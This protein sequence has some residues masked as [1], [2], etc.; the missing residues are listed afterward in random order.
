M[1][2][3]SYS[4]LVGVCLFCLP[5]VLSGQVSQNGN[6][7]QAA[8]EQAL[9]QI[10]AFNNDSA[11]VILSRLAAELSRTGDLSSPF[12]AKVRMRRAEALEK[13]DQD[14]QAIRELLQ[15][16]E[17]SKQA[18]YWKEYANAQLSLARLYEKRGMRRRCRLRLAQA[19]AAVESNALDSLYPRLYIRLSSY[20]RIFARRDSALVYARQVVRK[21]PALG[22]EEHAATG[23]MLLGMLL[24]DHSH[25]RAI[26]HFQQAAQTY[27][28]KGN[29]SGYSYMMGNISKLYLK[30]GYPYRALEY[31]D[32]FLLAARHAEGLGQHNASFLSYYYEGRGNIFEALGE[33]DSAL[34]YTR[35]EHALRSRELVE[36]N[37][38][39]IIEI[40]AQFKDEQKAR[41]I[42]EQEQLLAFEQSRRNGLVGLSLI[43]LFFMGVFF[44]LYTALRA[45]N[46]KTI[47][48]SNT[49][50]QTNE[51]LTYSLERQMALQAEIHH[52]VK[53]NLQVIISLLDAQR[54]GIEDAEALESLDA[55]SSRIYSMAAVHQI[56][57]QR[58]GEGSISLQDYALTLCQHLRHFSAEG[59]QAQFQLELK[60]HRFNLETLMPIGILLNEM[61]TNSLKYAVIPGRQLMIRMR[62]QVCGDGFCLNYQDNGP[63]F[64]EGELVEREGGL[65][66]YL[67]KSMVR[68]LD[69]RL[70]SHNENGAVY[71]VFFKE[72]HKPS[73]HEALSYNDR[74]G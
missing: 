67:L 21:A 13:A 1:N 19:T 61:V 36:S 30:H 74:R 29:Y 73:G 45:A 70:Q 66:T 56:L 51:E 58:K 68:Q 11:I 8:F 17:A 41:K 62:L 39:K 22:Q 32:S 63:G 25:K 5:S 9:A 6:N 18:G 46:R 27:R 52:R 43:L 38:E 72:K 14:E 60:S 54:E 33:L 44:Y 3:N 47:Q 59:E 50:R 2:N 69:G 7:Q 53:N 12:G 34:F 23:H 48:Q 65:G 20:H 28:R 31:S 26:E 10:E 49:I 42:E 24:R 16:S 64:P 57:C 71:Q 55:M 15:V 35:L 40:E 4:F 37:H